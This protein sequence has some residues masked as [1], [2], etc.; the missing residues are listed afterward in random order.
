MLF[1]PK[2]L[3]KYLSAEGANAML[4]CEVPE[5]WFRLPNKLND[6][7]DLTP[8]GSYADEFGGIGVFCMSESATSAPMWAHYASEGKGIVLEFSVSSDFL[9]TYTPVQVRY[10]RQRPTVK[11]PIKALTQKNRE[12]K[13]EREWRCFV[14][15]PSTMQGANRFLAHE[16]AIS[17]PLDLKSVTAIIHGHDSQVDTNQFLGR[18]D[19]VHIQEFVCRINAWKYGF[20]IREMA[21]IG[22]LFEQ[23]DA[24]LWGRRHRK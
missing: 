17:V 16:Q 11:N 23:R 10:G 3:Y 21:D 7:Y 9:Q 2:K 20:S 8:I 6:P 5:L 15:P 14:T 24:M 18:R 4:S 13:Y 22:H 19:A 12:W 1:R